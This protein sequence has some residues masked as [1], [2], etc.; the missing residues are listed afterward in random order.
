MNLRQPIFLTLLNFP[1]G[2]AVNTGL[3]FCFVVPLKEGR[4]SQSF[5]KSLLTV[6]TD[7]LFLMT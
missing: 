2:S 5:L 3:I 7:S 1:P 4:V 6:N